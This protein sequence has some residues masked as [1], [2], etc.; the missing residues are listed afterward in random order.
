MLS[1]SFKRAE[2]E[3]HF[4]LFLSFFLQFMVGQW[5]EGSGVLHASSKERVPCP[6]KSLCMI[7][8]HCK[9][10][11]YIKA[12][13][14]LKGGRGSYIILSNNKRVS[15]QLK[16]EGPLHRYMSAKEALLDL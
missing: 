13:N 3:R 5:R 15:G 11:K 16:R 7:G 9:K 10:S 1:E 6:L 8:P 4:I 2:Q 14:A 12:M